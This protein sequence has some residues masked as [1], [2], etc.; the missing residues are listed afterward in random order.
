MLHRATARVGAAVAAQS[1][2]ATAVSS[3]R[4][5][6]YAAPV[7]SL[8]K[9]IAQF[10]ADVDVEYPRFAVWGPRVPLEVTETYEEDLKT[11]WQQH[12]D[13]VNDLDVT[14]R[15]TLNDFVAE[16]PP[17]EVDKVQMPHPKNALGV[18]DTTEKHFDAFMG[19]A[20]NQRVLFP[21]CGGW[22][23]EMGSFA[24]MGHQVVGVDFC[25]S[26]V[27]ALNLYEILPTFHE[28]GYRENFLIHHSPE[29]GAIVAE[30]DFFKATAEELGTFDKVFDRAGISSIP[31]GR[32]PEYAKVLSGLMKPGATL[33]L[34]TMSASGT[35]E[36]EN[37]SYSWVNPE[38]VKKAFAGKE[39][40]VQELSN[41]DVS[42][43]WPYSETGLKGL[44]L[45]NFLITRA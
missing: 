32:I 36:G 5:V 15:K 25:R 30:G 24:H 20:K 43:T 44:K 11:Y 19:T 23:Y 27:D 38:N 34:E 16:L 45:H 9:D 8:A 17:S 33:L 26:A 31:E 21:M 39:W 35:E 22:N 3:K 14:L 41:E 37:S 4:A 13:E 42:A 40:K 29:S 12:W 7:A 6:S 2:T 1:A 28:E 10:N 18:S